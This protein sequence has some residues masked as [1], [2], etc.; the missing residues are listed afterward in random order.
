MRDAAR[1]LAIDHLVHHVAELIQALAD[2]AGAKLLILASSKPGLIVV[3]E[4]SVQEQPILACQVQAQ[5]IEQRQRHSIALRLPSQIKLTARKQAAP[6]RR[7]KAY[8]KIQKGQ[9][10][11]AVPGC[12][13]FKNHV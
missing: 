12:K 3:H 4:T 1:R 13:K 7:C 2:G 9:H 11:L 5:H 6:A 10:A 8:A